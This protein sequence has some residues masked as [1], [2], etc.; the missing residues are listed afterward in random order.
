MSINN[1]IEI[2][3]AVR[4]RQT[5]LLVLDGNLIRQKFSELQGTLVN[6]RIYY[7][8]KTNPHW[9]VIDLLNDLGCGFEISSQ[10]ELGLLLH[11][12]ISPDRIIASN[13]VKTEA[14]IEAAYRLG[15]RLFAFDSYAEVE[16]LSQFAPQSKV[17]VRLTVPNDGSKWPLTK[18]FGVEVDDA[19]ELLQEARSK[20]LEPYGLTF[21]VGSQCTEAETWVKALEK[22]SVVWE[23]ARER[24]I[25]LKMLNI[26]G[27]FPIEY[28]ETTIPIS[29]IASRIKD[30]ID[31]LFPRDTEVAIEPGRVLV[32]EAGVLVATVIGKAVRNKEKWLY[33]DVGVFNG[34]MESIGGIQYSLA[35][36]KDGIL[37]PWV[38]AGPSCDSLDIVQSDVF[39]PEMAIGD[40]VYILS[41]GAYTTAY[42]SQ[43]DGITIPQTTLL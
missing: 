8:L 11:R 42:A 25:E 16:K 40:H 28:R 21:H 2:E 13:P 35:S 14:F 31:T 19:V 32:G 33:L 20:G 1:L 26:G 37:E 10:D 17:Y 23:K 24:G 9:L 36:L 15:M 18:K 4:G 22:S 43:F 34:L 3:N 12:A 7:A 27:G 30:T 38:L 41:A 29:D 39:L 6:S 5:P